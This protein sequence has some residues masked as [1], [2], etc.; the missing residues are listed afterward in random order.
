MEKLAGRWAGEGT[1]VPTRGPNERFRCVVNYAVGAAASRL[2]QHL[3]CHGND[4][5][6]EAVT[7][8]DIRDGR[9]TRGQKIPTR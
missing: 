1:M 8:L 6:F 4:T 5:R 7:R 3:R 2:R 9:V